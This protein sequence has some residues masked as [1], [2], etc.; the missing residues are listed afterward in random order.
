M[1]GN[2]TN[3]DGLKRNKDGTFTIIETKN[4]K[5]PKLSKGQK[6][7]REHVMKG[8]QKFEVKSDVPELGITAGTPIQVSNYITVFKR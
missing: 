7:A 4:S 8:N 6:S 3:V 2:R 5:S 1:K